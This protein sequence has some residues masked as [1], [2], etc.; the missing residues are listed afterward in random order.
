MP[1][2]VTMSEFINQLYKQINDI[3]KKGVT[4]NVDYEKSKVIHNK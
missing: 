2:C 1:T 4:S 3:D